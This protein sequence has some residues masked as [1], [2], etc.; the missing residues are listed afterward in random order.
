M[1]IG[2]EPN[3]ESK[4]RRTEDRVAPLESKVQDRGSGMTGMRR[5]VV[6]RACHIGMALLTALPVSTGNARTLVISVHVFE[7]VPPC[8]NLLLACISCTTATEQGCWPA[9]DLWTLLTL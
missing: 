5:V 1:K 6:T 2:S 9:N 3:A 7:A 4:L 8:E